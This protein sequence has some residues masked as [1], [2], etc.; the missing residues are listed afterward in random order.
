MEDRAD[1]LMGEELGH[2]HQEID[3]ALGERPIAEDDCMKVSSQIPLVS[4]W[5]QLGCEQGVRSSRCDAGSA[6]ASGRGE[7]R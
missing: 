2:Q 6:R 7:L 4:E 3:S 1:A 5:A